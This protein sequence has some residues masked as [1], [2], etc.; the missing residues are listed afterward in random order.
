MPESDWSPARRSAQAWIEEAVAAGRTNTD[1][2]NTLR[3]SGFGYRESDVR[4]DA[5]RLREQGTDAAVFRAYDP[6]ARIPVEMIREVETGSMVIK[7]A[8]RADFICE[9]HDAVT[10][11]VSYNKFSY[12]FSTPL[13]INA[14]T[15]AMR[16]QTHWT[17][18]SPQGRIAQAT[19]TKI[20]AKAVE[21]W[22][23][24]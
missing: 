12:S 19:L 17:P 20:F 13:S 15:D 6:Q 1:I 4:Q 7:E 22:E 14:L 10:G 23:E 24:M 21:D 2:Y 16:E 11:K 9:W 3:T 18:E 5:N 8:F